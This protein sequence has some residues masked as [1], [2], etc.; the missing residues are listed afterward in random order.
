LQ[1]NVLRLLPSDDRLDGRREPEMAAHLEQDEIVLH[2]RVLPP[3]LEQIAEATSV[4]LVC[5]I[6]AAASGLGELLDAELLD[7]IHLA[8]ARAAGDLPEGA[9]VE[10]PA[11]LRLRGRQ[12]S[13]RERPEKPPREARFLLDHPQRVAVLGHRPLAEHLAREDDLRPDRVGML[14]RLV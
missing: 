8:I 7:Q 6:A 10:L 4:V 3:M 5:E 12:V 1:E 13:R 11:S 9:A 2:D 14:L